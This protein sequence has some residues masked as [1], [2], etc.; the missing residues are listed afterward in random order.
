MRDDRISRRYTLVFP[1]K[2]PPL[3]CRRVHVES[4]SSCV[5]SG[6]AV[7]PLPLILKN[8]IIS[9]QHPRFLDALPLDRPLDG[10]ILLYRIVGP[11]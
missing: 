2:L 1:A 3:V 7:V 4:R 9:M 6:Q 8:Q 11:R 5:R 10:V